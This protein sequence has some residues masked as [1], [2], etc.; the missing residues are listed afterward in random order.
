[1]STASPPDLL[2]CFWTWRWQQSKLMY[3]Q[4]SP[5]PF[6]SMEIWAAYNSVLKSI[7]T[8]KQLGVWVTSQFYKLRAILLVI[9]NY[10]TSRSES[11]EQNYNTVWQ[12]NE[13][14]K[15]KQNV[16]VTH[17]IDSTARLELLSRTETW[18]KCFQQGVAKTS[19]ATAMS[20]S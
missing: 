14:L 5:K 12:F 6:A 3:S 17:T 8:G 19:A 16:H 15:H 9:W 20:R 11:L 7:D 10:F 2:R 4:L 1:M 18:D 13:I